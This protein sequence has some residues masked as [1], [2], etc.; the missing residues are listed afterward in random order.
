MIASN[1]KEFDLLNSWDFETIVLD[2]NS[3]KPVVVR[4]SKVEKE[5][6]EFQDSGALYK[7]PADYFIG[8]GKDKVRVGDILAK[9]LTEL[10]DKFGQKRQ[11][12]NVKSLGKIWYGNP[13]EINSWFSNRYIVSKS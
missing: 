7:L 8:V 4:V 5:V 2:I 10:V 1:G 12:T 11:I 9:K 3:R 6:I 13:N